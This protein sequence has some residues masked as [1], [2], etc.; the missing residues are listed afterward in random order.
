MNIM[1][2]LHNKLDKFMQ[3]LNK[4]IISDNITV[5]TILSTTIRLE[6][7]AIASMEDM[8]REKITYISF[9]MMTGYWRQRRC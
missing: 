5:S 8:V 4:P 6:Q 3:D 2:I 9:L 1:N 7:I